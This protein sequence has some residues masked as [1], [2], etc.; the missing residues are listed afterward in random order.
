MNTT[1]ISKVIANLVVVALSFIEKKFIS[2][3]SSPLVRD[4]LKLSLQPTKLTAFALADDNPRN[5]EQVE[6]IWKRFANVEVSAF[7]DR[8]IRKAVAGLKDE[9][10]KAILNHLAIPV[11]RLLQ[12]VTD[13][14]PD[15]E[16]QAKAELAAF[17]KDSATEGVLFNNF[18]IP[19]LATKIKDEAM[20]D[21]IITILKEA[22]DSIFEDPSDVPEEIDFEEQE[23]ETPRKKRK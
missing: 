7:T 12:I 14:N 5:Q 10:L 1:L 18:I 11:V 23:E 16:G 6:E 15:N 13:E 20:R 2:K 17:I 21:L 3:I 8:E 9:N 4:G 19:V 22:A